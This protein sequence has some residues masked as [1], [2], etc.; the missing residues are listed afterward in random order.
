MT[1]KQRG[2]MNARALIIIVPSFS[3]NAFVP[4][5]HIY[6]VEDVETQAVVLG[7]EVIQSQRL[8]CMMTLSNGQLPKPGSLC[9]REMF[10][11]RTCKNTT[12][13]E[14]HWCV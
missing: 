12:Q 2:G 6:Q 7:R 5:S 8:H 13:L 9:C 3:F 14:M 10:K 4:S 1:L 11:P